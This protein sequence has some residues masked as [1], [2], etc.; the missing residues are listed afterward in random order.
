MRFVSY[1]TYIQRNERHLTKNTSK[2]ERNG[3]KRNETRHSLSDGRHISFAA[4]LETMIHHSTTY[5]HHLIYEL[6]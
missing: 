5:G 4:Y 3:R 1:F 6:C 2:F